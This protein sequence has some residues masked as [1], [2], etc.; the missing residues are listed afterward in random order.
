MEQGNR[1]P[2]ILGVRPR[3]LSTPVSY[4]VTLLEGRVSGKKH[5]IKEFPG[6][7]SRSESNGARTELMD[8]DCK[9]KRNSKETGVGQ[10][11][12]SNRKEKI[13]QD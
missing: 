9:K 6:K 1:Q 4:W 3:C 10:Q 8:L 7:M 5:K 11:S 13:N 12:K 2:L